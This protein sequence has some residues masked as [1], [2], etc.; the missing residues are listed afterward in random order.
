MTD[1]P[2]LDEGAAIAVIS[3]AVLEV[4]KT[5][6]STAP[7]LKEVRLK[8]K[9]DWDTAQQL[10]DADVLTGIVV[11]LMGLAGVVLMNKKYPLV[12]LILTWVLV[13][14]YYHLVRRSPNSYSAA[15]EEGLI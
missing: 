13:A 8:S 4:F 6:K 3:F 2:K 11:V 9:D 10:L 12:F 14:G 15:R 1:V 7:P 5:Y